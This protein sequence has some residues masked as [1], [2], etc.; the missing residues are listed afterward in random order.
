LKPEEFSIV[1]PQ[2]AVWQL[3]EQWQFLGP[4]VSVPRALVD[5]GEVLEHFFRCAFLRLIDFPQQ[6][7]FVFDRCVFVRRLMPLKRGALLARPPRLLGDALPFL[8]GTC[9]ADLVADLRDPFLTLVPGVLSPV[10]EDKAAKALEAKGLSAKEARAAL[11]D[12]LAAS[13]AAASSSSTGNVESKGDSK[14]ESKGD[15]AELQPD[16]AADDSHAWTSK[17][18]P[19][20]Y[21][22]LF[23]KKSAMHT[24]HVPAPKSHGPDAWLASSTL[25][26]GARGVVGFS[27]KLYASSSDNL[28]ASLLQDEIAK[29]SLM[30]RDTAPD[31]YSRRLL[32]VIAPNLGG[33]MQCAGQVL[34]GDKVG[35]RFRL[36]VK[37]FKRLEDSAKSPKKVLC[38][39]VHLS[40]VNMSFASCAWAGIG[41]SP[42]WAATLG[43]RRDAAR[44]HV[45]QAQ[46]AA[47]TCVC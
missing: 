36:S 40:V 45:W 2:F 25:S 4:L 37:T 19:S 17:M 47:A 14:G 11:A 15:G 29:F 16:D 12:R 8:A 26:G 27:H 31:L 3:S 33:L 41:A 44:S 13:D 23:A 30:F 22:A 7:L 46:L 43:S 42:C 28:T 9:A 6:A 18:Y 1:L 24:L 35:A 39:N 20:A 10:Q 34:D 21:P 38:S 5:P 32:V